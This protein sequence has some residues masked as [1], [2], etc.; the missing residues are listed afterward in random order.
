MPDFPA[1]SGGGILDQGNTTGSSAGV[2]ITAHASANTKGNWSEL[3]SSTTAR[4]D[5]LVVMLR[6]STV[7]TQAMACDL[8]VGAS[9]A[10]KVLVPDLF[11]DSVGAVAQGVSRAY[12]L[13]L[14]VAAGVRLS[15]RCQSTTG[16]GTLSCA[17]LV[18]GGTMIGSAACGQVEAC[19]VT[20]SAATRLTA[21]DPGGSVNT[22]SAWTQL[23]AST[24]F[25]YTYI[26]IA[27]GHGASTTGLNAPYLVDFA[28][29][30]NPNEKAILSDIALKSATITDSPPVVVATPL[31]VPSGSR[32][33]ARLR[34]TSTTATDRILDVAV[35]GVG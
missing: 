3:L 23:I 21:I 18:V 13:P 9:T 5:W 33:S 27:F 28:I 7:A 25:P 19:G 12:S 6:P 24:T 16:G 32:L 35:W 20:T 29:G 31:S 2:T 8:G 15:A 22:D 34:C 26:L 1:I 17:V 11:V 4:G 14:S 30:A 10:E